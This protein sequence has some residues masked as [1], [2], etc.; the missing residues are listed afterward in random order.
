MKRILLV[1]K[2]NNNTRELFERLSRRFQVQVSAEKTEIVQGMIE[3]TSPDM[4]LLNVMEY[5]DIDDSVLG[6]LENTYG[7]IPVL[8]MA[9]RLAVTAINH[10]LKR[11]SS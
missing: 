7:D 8:V 5:E 11:N 9:H 6:L 1:G 3:V 4:V 10:I 2:L